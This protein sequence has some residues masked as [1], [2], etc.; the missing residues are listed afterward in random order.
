M[1]DPNRVWEDFIVRPVRGLTVHELQAERDRCVRK[2]GEL[3][4]IAR[5]VDVTWIDRTID[6]GGRISLVGGFPLLALQPPAALTLWAL[7]AG[8]LA[9]GN[10]RKNRALRKLETVD[11]LIDLYQ[12]R[13]DDIIEELLFRNG[14]SA[15]R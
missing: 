8:T 13:M 12:Q 3:R 1:D 5:S 4:D 11:V 9:A 10:W 6:W 14:G 15:R 2:L 7:G